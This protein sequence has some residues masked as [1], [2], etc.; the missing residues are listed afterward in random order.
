[1]CVRA[2]ARVCVCV[3]MCMCAFVLMVVFDL[4]EQHRDS[5]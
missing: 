3:C 1:M 2:R 4:F 5:K